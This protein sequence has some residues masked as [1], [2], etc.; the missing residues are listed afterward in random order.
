[1]MTVDQALRHAQVLG[2]DRLDAQLLVLHA[3]GRGEHDRASPRAAP[4]RE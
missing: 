2:L 1:M 3:L 4:R